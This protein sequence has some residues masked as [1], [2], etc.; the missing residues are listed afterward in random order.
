MYICVTLVIADPGQLLAGTIDVTSKGR[1]V[2]SNN[3]TL[4]QAKMLALNQARA[5]AVE[6]AGGVSTRRFTIVKDNIF[7]ADFIKA[8]SSGFLVEEKRLN[9]RGYWTDANAGELGLPVVEVTIKARVESKK[10][11]FLRPQLINASLNR[12]S[13]MDGDKASITVASKTD[14]FVIIVN[15]TST[16]KIVPIYPNHFDNKN[17]LPAGIKLNYPSK[18][19][20]PFIVKNYPQNNFDTEAFFVFGLPSNSVTQKLAWLETFPAGEQM[21]YAEFFQRLVAISM[22]WLSEDILVYTVSKGKN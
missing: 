17:Y 3:I 14:V 7:A 12:S 21:E 1:A 20:A 4:D 8:F 6:K 16:G 19:A 15:Y 13:Y 18:G 9:W 5:M 10:Q 2:I 11:D 22:D